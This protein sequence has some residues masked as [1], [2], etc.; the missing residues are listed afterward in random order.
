MFCYLD[1]RSFQNVASLL[2]INYLDLVLLDPVTVQDKA[3]TKNP[4]ALSEG[5]LK[6]WGNG[7]LSFANGQVTAE[8][9][10]KVIK[11]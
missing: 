9:A 10:G 8:R 1:L 4:H 6:V 11:E 3:A 5:I 2:K 7:K